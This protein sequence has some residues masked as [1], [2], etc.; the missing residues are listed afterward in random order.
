MQQAI[1]QRDD[2]RGV[3][4]DLI[5]FFKGPVGGEDYRLAF[6]PPVDDLLE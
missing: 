4:K 6:I 5:P 2:A 3:G 1:Q